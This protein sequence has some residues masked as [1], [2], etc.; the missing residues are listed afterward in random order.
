MAIGG[1]EDADQKRSDFC[2]R[3]EEDLARFLESV[4]GDESPRTRNESLEPRPKG[5]R[6]SK[7]VQFFRYNEQG[8]R[9]LKMCPPH[10]EENALGGCSVDHGFQH[11]IVQKNGCARRQGAERCYLDHGGRLSHCPVA[12]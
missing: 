5:V 8:E 2:D 11:K 6:T 12:T 4:S 7:K 3:M 1:W 9:V 10:C